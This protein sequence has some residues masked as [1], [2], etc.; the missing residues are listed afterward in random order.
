[1]RSGD[2]GETLLELVVAVAIMGVAIVA[3]I[4]GMSVGIMMSDIHRK[5]ATAG[6]AARDYAET[7][8]AW[9]AAG[10]Y[11]ASTTPVYTPATVHYSAPAGYTATQVSVSCWTG[12][13]AW[14]SCASNQK[15]L[16]QLTVQVASNDGRASE[17]VAVVLR[18]PCRLGDTLC[19]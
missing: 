6:T 11:D 4:G 18:K 2:R 9:V 7:A 10:H 16:E 15:G 17:R 8:E 5:Q 12:A 14:Q 1:V 3:I 13:G 19:S